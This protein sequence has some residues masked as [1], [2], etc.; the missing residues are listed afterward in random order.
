MNKET[1]APKVGRTSPSMVEN[2]Y[3]IIDSK[4][5]Y[6]D[7]QTRELLRPLIGE[8]T[9]RDNKSHQNTGPKDL[10]MTEKWF[11][12][13]EQHSRVKKTLLL[14]RNYLDK[15]NA[16]LVLSLLADDQLAQLSQKDLEY[17]LG[18]QQRYR[19]A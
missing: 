17:K 4:I 18:I 6:L 14:L 8:N 12:A 11:L 2:I 13:F 19:A 15:E 7:Y 5:Q 9:Q 1:C 10:Q 3:S 16:L